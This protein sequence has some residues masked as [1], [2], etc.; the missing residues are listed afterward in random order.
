V[1]GIALGFVG[2]VIVYYPSGL[3][4]TSD[5]LGM[6]SIVLSSLMYSFMIIAMKSELHRYSSLQAIYFQ[7]VAGAVLLAPFL[8]TVAP[9]PSGEQLLIALAYGFLIGFVAFGIYFYALK[10]LSIATASGLTYVEVISAIS[11]G[12][13]LFDESLSWNLLFGGICII[14]SSAIIVHGRTS[15]LN[16]VVAQEVAE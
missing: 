14:C 15:R 4:I 16:L 6:G 9:F 1:L 2:A 13:L 12:I 11:F 3:S 7:N 5:T 8:I 10:D